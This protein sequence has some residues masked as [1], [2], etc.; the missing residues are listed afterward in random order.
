VRRLERQFDH[1]LNDLRDVFN[2]IYDILD[3]K[4]EKPAYAA[5]ERYDEHYDA[6]IEELYDLTS[7]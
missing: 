3:G 7:P 4:S 5:I 2:A 6:T 1:A